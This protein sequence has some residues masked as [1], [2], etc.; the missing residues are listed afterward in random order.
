MQ[1]GAM[2]LGGRGGG[3][4][5]FLDRR[6]RLVRGLAELGLDHRGRPA[7]E[8][9]P[10]RPAGGRT[11]SSSPTAARP[12]GRPASGRSSRTSA[13]AA[14]GARRRAGA[15]SSSANRISPRMCCSNQRRTPP[16]GVPSNAMSML[17]WYSASYT[18]WRRRFSMIALRR[19]VG[20]DSSSVQT[21]GAAVMPTWGRLSPSTMSATRRRR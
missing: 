17:V 21:D 9:A 1:R 4:R 14:G 11:R 7:R 6:E 20:S 5:L 19:G 18:C 8:T 3:E 16:I 2:D 10:R 15:L 12:S 13:P